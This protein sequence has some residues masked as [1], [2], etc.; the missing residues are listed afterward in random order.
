[1]ASFTGED[2]APPLIFCRHGI[3]SVLALSRTG[4]IPLILVIAL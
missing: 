2:G 4:I 3:A 1:M